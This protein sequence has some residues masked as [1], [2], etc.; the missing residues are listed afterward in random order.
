[1]GGGQRTGT[2]ADFRRRPR[3]NRQRGD[4]KAQIPAII[5]RNLILPGSDTF[6]GVCDNH[7]PVTLEHIRHH[8]LKDNA[9]P[10]YVQQ[11]RRVPAVA[12]HLPPRSPARAHA[13]I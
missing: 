10:A 1:M 7:I 5:S 13:H 4:K 8:L 11:P 12:S 2:Q 9:G 3:K 6:T